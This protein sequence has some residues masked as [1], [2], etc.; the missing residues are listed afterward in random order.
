MSISGKVF[1]SSSLLVGLRISHR[2]IG[3]IG[4]LILA[5]LLTP[6]DFAVIALTSIVIYFFDMLSHIG[7]EQYILQKNKVSVDDLNTAWSLD[8]ALKSCIWLMLICLIPSISYFFSQPKLENTLYFSSFILLSNALRNPG[9]WILKK[10]LNYQKI[11][12]LSII[13]KLISFS[14][15]MIIVTITKSFWAIIIGELISS[16]IFSIGS[17]FIHSHRPKISFSQAKKQW[18]FSKWLL[19]KGI[20]GYA[21]AQIDTLIV[22]KFFNASLIGMYHISRDLAMFPAQNLLAPAIEPLLTAFQKIKHNK[23]NLE[24]QFRF[25]LF[26]V[27]IISLPIALYLW[28]FPTLIV[29]TILGQQWIEASGMFQVMSLLFLYFSFMLIIEQALIA[30]KQIKLL[31]FYDLF[32]L[33]VIASILLVAA[34][35]QSDI[36]SIALYRGVIGIAMTLI[37]LTYLIILIKIKVNTFILLLSFPLIASFITMKINQIIPLPLFEYSIINLLLSASI[38]FTVYCLIMSF[39]IYIFKDLTEIKHFIK[40]ILQL[41]IFSN[42]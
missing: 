26:I 42:R 14:I 11:F 35:N 5:R 36:E 31:F 16:V 39:I 29:E 9:H 33:I 27:S 30:L 17:Y 21:R 32:S 3:L 6:S 38:F 7:S 2:L 4:I 19:L 22:A 25:C 28:C 12:N 24:F 41:K 34:F 37:L 1:K 10:E 8:I 23:E 40:L 20:F 13:Q 15:V 18:Q